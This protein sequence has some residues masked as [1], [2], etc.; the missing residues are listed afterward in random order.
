M[1]GNL[2]FIS[3][4]FYRNRML[5]GKI[6]NTIGY[7]DGTLIK[8]RN[9]PSVE[10]NRHAFMGRKS[11]ASINVQFVSLYWKRVMLKGLQHNVLLLL[12]DFRPVIDVYTL[13]MC[14]LGSLVRRMILSFLTQ[15]GLE[16]GWLNCTHCDPTA[17]C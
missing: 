4:R 16:K 17:T 5:G 7:T 12:T 1:C 6:P 15:V 13:I 3:V 14:W 9:K 10:N 2:C 11:F 8:I